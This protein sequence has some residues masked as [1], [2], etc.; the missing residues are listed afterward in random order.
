MQATELSDA[1]PRFAATAAVI[2]PY[3]TFLSDIFVVVVFNV[4]LIAV[5]FVAE[6]KI[7]KGN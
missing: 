2:G 6:E 7:N 5:S 3:L 4:I 1:N